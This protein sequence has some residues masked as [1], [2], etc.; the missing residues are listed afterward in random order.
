[1]SVIATAVK[2]MLAANMSHE[3]IVLAIAEMEQ[4]NAPSAVT[5]KRQER[6]RR[7]YER[8]KASEKR[9][10]KTEQDVSDG[11]NLS[12][13]KRS[14]IPPKKLTPINPPSPPKG[15][16]S[17]TDFDHSEALEAYQATASRCDLPS[18]RV[19]T[20]A[21][22]Q[23]LAAVLRQHG[24]PVW[25]EALAKIEASSFCTGGNDR[26]WRADLDFLLQ[27]SSFAAILEG[28]YD[29]RQGKR[30]E[31]PPKPRSI[32][33]ALRDEARRHG[34]L[35]DE[36]DSQNRGFYGEGHSGGN[37]RVLDLAFKPA[38]KGFG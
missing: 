37:V 12:P 10:N 35:R 34:V 6:N 28:R 27:P 16:S 30:K 15:G 25:L 32:G 21:R 9:L 18:V 24:L 8:L 17:P 19:L 2:H 13:E 26:G 29:N 31:P 20:A 7:Y 5:N 22:K 4:S 33:D 14:P 38:L 3:D 11:G 23:K 1:M 36:P